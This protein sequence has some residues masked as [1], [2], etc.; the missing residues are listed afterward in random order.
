MSSPDG[1]GPLTVT[2]TVLGDGC[3]QLR[4]PPTDADEL[5]N[6]L[7]EHGIEH[8]TA[9]EFASDPSDWIEA[10]KVVGGAVGAGGGLAGIAAV[11]RAH[12]RRH[13][14]KRVH[15][16]IDG[17]EID[18]TGYSEPEVEKLL[19]RAAEAQAAADERTRKAMGQPAAEEPATPQDD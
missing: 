11:I 18:A 13:D 3:I 2:T 7:D 9:A 19:D 8:S 12:T 16:K 17:D 6:L 1:A 10:V 4:F 14:G 5:R 15:F